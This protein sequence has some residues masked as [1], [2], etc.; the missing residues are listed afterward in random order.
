[1]LSEGWKGGKLVA[2]G[3]N[4]ELSRNSDVWAQSSQAASTLM[5]QI[6]QSTE[7]SKATVITRDWNW[8]VSSMIL[9]IISSESDYMQIYGMCISYCS[10]WNFLISFLNLWKI[11]TLVF[12]FR[13][14]I[15]DRIFIIFHVFSSLIFYLD[16][17][18]SFFLKTIL[19]D[20]AFCLHVYLWPCLC[21]VPMPV[22]DRGEYWIF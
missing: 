16:Y 3:E 20:L 1:M 13:Q 18:F 14:W 8:L 22:E 21:T 12:L 15:T 5:A 10:N 6:S 4:G 17:Q 2:V 19:C 11:C 7:T 9:E